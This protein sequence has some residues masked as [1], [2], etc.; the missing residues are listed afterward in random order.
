MS[1]GFHF[2]RLGGGRYQV[3]AHTGHLI[4]EISKHQRRWPTLVLTY[5]AA[6]TLNGEKLGEYR[7]RRDAAEALTSQVD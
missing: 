2:K 6:R 3:W 1:S 5:W 4:G 7:I